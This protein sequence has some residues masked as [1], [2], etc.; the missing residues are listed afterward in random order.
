MKY[1]DDLTKSA[2][3]F[4]A[5][6]LS[7][8]TPQG[9]AVAAGNAA[10]SLVMNVWNSHSSKR[11]EKKARLA[12]SASQ[13]QSNAESLMPNRIVEGQ[14]ISELQARTVAYGTPMA[15]PFGIVR[16]ITGI[17]IEQANPVLTSLYSPL[18]NSWENTYNLSYI[19]SAGEGVQ[20]L[21]RAWYNDE[22]VYDRNNGGNLLPSGVLQGQWYTGTQDQTINP[23]HYVT[24]GPKKP[25]VRTTD[26]S[27]IISG[28]YVLILG[29]VNYANNF[30]ELYLASSDPRSY[31]DSWG[32]QGAASQLGYNNNGWTDGFHSRVLAGNVKSATQV[33][34]DLSVVNLSRIDIVDENGNNW[35]NPYTNIQDTN[36]YIA[37]GDVN[38]SGGLEVWN[39]LQK[40]TAESYCCIHSFGQGEGSN[41]ASGLITGYRNGDTFLNVNI[42]Q[43]R[44]A[45]GDERGIWQKINGSWGNINAQQGQ[46]N[47]FTYFQKYGNP[48]QHRYA[49]LLPA[50]WYFSF[51]NRY[52]IQSPTGIIIDNSGSPR[53][54]YRG[55]AVFCITRHLTDHAEIGN[56]Q[57]E[58][59]RTGT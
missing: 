28:K 4:A 50:E 3:T 59:I 41:V 31:T 43:R 6:A 19:V 44:N 5:G 39:T 52:Q 16:P 40:L 14:S 12:A 23:S 58:T 11:K 2:L 7:N 22:L 29:W 10:A 47:F 24:Y 13:I 36:Y 48:R 38:Q 49:W 57:F 46:I 32:Y 1:K 56:W 54:N 42:D 20:N 53:M 37:G 8:P 45:S 27:G 35:A 55:E 18:S 30:V 15:L 17:I 9:A 26:I 51:N 25:I 21:Q 33:D 34:W